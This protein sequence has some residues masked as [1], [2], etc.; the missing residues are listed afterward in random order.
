MVR[1]LSGKVSFFGEPLKRVRKRIAYVPQKNSVDWDF[2]ITAFEVVLMG[3][4]G[5]LGWWKWPR[6]A[7]KQAAIQ[8]LELV[9]MEGFANRQISQLSG[10]QQQRIF[11][12]RALLQDADLYLMDEPF[13]GVDMATEKAI[14][15]LLDQL[16][17]QGKTLL[18]VHH[19]LTTVDTYFDWVLLLNTCLIQ[20]GPVSEVF[21]QE[22][23]LRT[24]GRGGALLDEAAKL[25]HSKTLG[26]K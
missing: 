2:P 9:G 26:F 6:V 12:A 1:P 5:R 10:G 25:T 11:I 14:I 19:D 4:Y 7:D 23:I 17:A 24:Y 22:A 18:V 3:R 8:A 16:K 13:A 21:T 15:T 20:A